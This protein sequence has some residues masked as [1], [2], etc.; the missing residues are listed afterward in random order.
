MNRSCSSSSQAFFEIVTHLWAVKPIF[1][2]MCSPTREP[3]DH[4]QHGRVAAAFLCVEFLGCLTASWWR[5]R[6]LRSNKW[7]IELFKHFM[8][9]DP[10]AW[11]VFKGGAWSSMSSNWKEGLRCPWNA[12]YAVIST[13]NW[14]P[15]G[16]SGSPAPGS[17]AL[18]QLQYLGF[19]REYSAKNKEATRV[20][21]KKKQGGQP[22]NALAKRSRKKEK[23]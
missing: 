17:Q 21:I 11:S 19:C 7:S 20:A 18:E 6:R 2:I 9:H 13:R 8:W 16:T 23:T 3:R 14:P 4:V 1:Q 10:A 22:E 15:Q 5:I 12:W